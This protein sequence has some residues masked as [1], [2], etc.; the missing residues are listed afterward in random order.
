MMKSRSGLKRQRKFHYLLG[1]TEE[2][3]KFNT[4]AL[5][6]WLKENGNNYQNGIRTY[7][8]QLER[9]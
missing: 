2:Q 6:D 1:L 3:I 7:T 5:N 9:K 8:R 4:Q